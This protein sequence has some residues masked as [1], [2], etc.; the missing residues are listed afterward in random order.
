MNNC[1]KNFVCDKIQFFLANV[2]FLLNH[3]TPRPI[4]RNF[5]KLTCRRDRRP[6]LSAYGS[7]RERFGRFL[8][9]TKIILIVN[10]CCRILHLISQPAVASFP[11]RGSLWLGIIL[12]P[13]LWGVLGVLVPPYCL[14]LE[15]KGDRRSRWMRCRRRRRR[16]IIKIHNNLFQIGENDAYII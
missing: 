16:Y 5:L 9:S 11:S 1:G 3:P 13:L 6:R 12:S 14:P 7:L 15:G 10:G 4:L 8:S 2:W